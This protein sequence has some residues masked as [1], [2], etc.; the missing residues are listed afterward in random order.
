M[1]WCCDVR[2]G[3]G[4]AAHRSAAADPPWAVDS[5]VAQPLKTM[6]TS[7]DSRTKCNRLAAAIRDRWPPI[8]LIVVT[9][10][11][12]PSKSELPYDSLF[13]PKPYGGEILSAVRHFQ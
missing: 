10:F 2:Y 4:S 9:G 6:K 7:L 12:P 5:S 11:T 1:W 13:I 8:Y 3:R